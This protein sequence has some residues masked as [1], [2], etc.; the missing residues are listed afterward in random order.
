MVWIRGHRVENIVEGRRQGAA[1]PRDRNVLLPPSSRSR[2]TKF[3]C[4]SLVLQARIA[5]TPAS[6]RGTEG[7][8]YQA[9]HNASSAHVARYRRIKELLRGSA[10]ADEQAHLVNTFLAVA[11]ASSGESPAVSG[12]RRS[13]DATSAPFI[14]WLVSGKRFEAFDKNGIYSDTATLPATPLGP[15]LR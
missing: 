10:S 12:Q 7:S 13:I 8:Y 2:L 14:G 3:D 9:K 1:L 11:Q 6:E 15:R 5:L 4:F